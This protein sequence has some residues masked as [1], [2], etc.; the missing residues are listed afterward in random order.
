MKVRDIMS[1]NVA[2]VNPV[3]TVAEAARLMEEYNVGSI[4]VCDKKVLVGIVTDR[5]IVV[6][7]VACGKNPEKTPIRDV[8]SP[9]VTTVTPDTEVSDVAKVMGTKR[10][11]RLPVVE[12]NRLVGMLALGDVARRA[13]HDIEIADMLAI[14]TG[15]NSE[16][17]GQA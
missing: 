5:D 10:I 12:N 6:R 7:N 16:N 14:F 13:R 15:W 17:P 11:R 2:S 4:P 8:M 3:A 1:R 9:G